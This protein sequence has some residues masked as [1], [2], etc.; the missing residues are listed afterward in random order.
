MT[1]S[2]LPNLWLL[3]KN[4]SFRIEKNRSLLSLY[5]KCT[6]NVVARPGFLIITV[7]VV[8][9]FYVYGK[10]KYETHDGIQPSGCKVFSPPLVEW[11]IHKLIFWTNKSILNSFNTPPETHSPFRAPGPPLWEVLLQTDGCKV[12]WSSLELFPPN[13]FFFFFFLRSKD[14]KNKTHIV[15]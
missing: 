14:F 13:V 15:V 4:N 1:S 10:I 7:W 5:S 2:G 6:T 11:T 8:D 3:F 9:L 12:P